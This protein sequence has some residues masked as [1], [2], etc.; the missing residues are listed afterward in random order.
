MFYSQLQWTLKQV[1]KNKE[2][3]FVGLTS[4]KLLLDVSHCVVL[5][6]KSWVG[7]FDDLLSQHTIKFL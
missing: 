6:F 7:F 5:K 1:D 2:S 4:C 3:I